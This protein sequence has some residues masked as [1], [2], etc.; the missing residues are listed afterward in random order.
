MCLYH[1]YK[2]PNESCMILLI[3]NMPYTFYAII[4]N[5]AITTRNILLIQGNIFFDGGTCMSLLNL[6]SEYLS[7]C[8]SNKR[9]NPKTIKAYRNDLLQ[10]Y[11]HFKTFTDVN[12]PVSELEDFIATI[13]SQFKPRTAKRKIA[14]VKAF[15][16]HLEYKDII[17]TNPF[18]KINIKFQE[19]TE[20]PK[21]IPLTFVEAILKAAYDEILNGT[22][23][24]KRENAIRDVALIE[25]LFATGVRIS[26]LCHLEAQSIDF[27]HHT[28]LIYGKRSKERLI[29]IEN[30]STLAALQKYYD[31]YKDAI[32][33]CNIFFTNINGTPLSDQ[34]ARRIIRHY[35]NLASIELHITPRMFRHT[36]ATSLLD[37]D[38][39]IRYI[40]E[41]LGHSSIAVTQIYTHVS[42]SKQKEILATKHPRNRF[43][44]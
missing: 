30:E 26:E 36:F 40:Q 12:I 18:S 16:H 11:E 34:A 6:I 38:V 17:T 25:F 21:T 3:G 28:V 10:F 42:T 39:D 5:T 19:P 32:L 15:F 8:K 37:A 41:L 4:S 35:T 9:L 20:L 22:T 24:R 2:N 43:N 7:Y 27:A 1:A 33:C 31:S 29:Q 13:H 23:E 14:S 44:I